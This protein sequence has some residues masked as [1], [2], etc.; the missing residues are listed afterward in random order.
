MSRSG[1]K[2]RIYLVAM[3]DLPTAN[4]LHL[5]LDARLDFGAS[6]TD[7]FAVENWHQSFWAASPELLMLMTREELI[8]RAMRAGDR[9]S[10]HGF[11]MIF[12]RAVGSGDVLHY[13]WALRPKGIPPG[14]SSLLDAIRVAFEMEGLQEP[15][16]HAPHVTFVY[17]APGPLASFP[18]PPIEW[19]IREICLV[20]GVGRGKNYHYRTLAKWSLLPESESPNRQLGLI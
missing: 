17:Y 5:E 14:F 19:K 6:G 20:E 3:V 7:C 11:S 18:L 2:P 15:T 10:A 8:E 9:I 12:N 16:R 13:Q 4:S 1:R